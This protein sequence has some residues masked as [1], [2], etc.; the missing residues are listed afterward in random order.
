MKG[1]RFWIA[2]AVLFIVWMILDYLFHEVLLGDAYRATPGL[3]RSPEE[4]SR[5][6]PLM[7]LGTLIYCVF[8]VFVFSKGREG[9]GIR[10]GLRFGLSI[11][12]LFSAPMAIGSYVSMPLTGWLAGMWFVIGMVENL[13][14]GAITAAIYRPPGS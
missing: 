3:W 9:K 8:F 1:K 7:G 13:V 11:G 6:M 2:S 12:I 14:G 5:L 4:M 10:E